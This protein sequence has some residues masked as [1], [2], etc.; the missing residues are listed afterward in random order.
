MTKLHRVV[1]GRPVMCWMVH[2]RCVLLREA[3]RGGYAYP[4]VMGGVGGQYKETPMKN[5][6]SHI[7]NAMEYACSKLLIAGLSIPYEGK[8]L[9][10]MSVV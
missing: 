3:M 8:A 1:N 7:A 9:P 2:E 6:F 5:K 4:E 10:A